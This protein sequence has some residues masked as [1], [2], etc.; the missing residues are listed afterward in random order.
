MSKQ[1]KYVANKLLEQLHPK[2]NFLGKMPRE[3]SNEYV[4]NMARAIAD[5]ERKGIIV[6][7]VDDRFY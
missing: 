1:A 5:L 2:S 3:Q 4:K 6:F 7:P